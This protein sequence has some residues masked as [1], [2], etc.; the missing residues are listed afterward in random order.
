[1]QVSPLSLRGGLQADAA[2]QVLVAR[3]V[4]DGFALLA[5]TKEAGI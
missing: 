3:N 5:I 4:L 2:I 1:M